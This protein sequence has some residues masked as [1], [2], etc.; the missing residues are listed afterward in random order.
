LFHLSYSNTCATVNSTIFVFVN[1]P[2]QNLY[3]CAKSVDNDPWG[4]AGFNLEMKYVSWL[5]NVNSVQID[6]ANTAGSWLET[7]SRDAQCLPVTIDPNL[8]T[9]Q[10]RAY[11][12]CQTVGTSPPYGPLGNAVLAQL[13]VA[14]GL[15][16]ASTS[17]DLRGTAGE[18]TTAT[19]LVS[20]YWVPGDPEY[21]FGSV[22][23]PAAVGTVQVFLAPCADYVG[24]SGPQP[25]N[26]VSIFDI[27]HLAQ[28]IGRNS[29]QPGW[30]PD[31]DMNGDNAVSI[32]QDVLIG[33][34]QFGRTCQAV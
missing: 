9:G 8:E 21:P 7:T 16:K 31:W 27:L 2:P 15:T 18:P 19:H 26:A 6:G 32:T 14:P 10:G 4:A 20:A 34:K 3:L 33:A 24:F 28:K 11:G 13:V 5:V 29:T 22:L 1:R 30:N 17:I 25:D 23:I 12:S